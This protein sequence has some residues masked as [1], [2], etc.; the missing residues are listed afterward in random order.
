MT[1]NDWKLAVVGLKSLTTENGSEVS[2]IQL[3][4]FGK[5]VP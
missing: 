3:V 2:V 5:Q 4:R 1:I